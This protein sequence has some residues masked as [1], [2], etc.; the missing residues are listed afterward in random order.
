M[1]NQTQCVVLDLGLKKKK[2]VQKVFLGYLEKFEYGQDR[3]GYYEI[4]THSFG[5]YN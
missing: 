3:W 2:K 4:I 5:A 1:Y